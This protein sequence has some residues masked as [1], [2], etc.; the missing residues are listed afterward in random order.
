VVPKASA[1]VPGQANAEP[2]A[3]YADHINMVKFSRNNDRGYIKVS[4]TLQIMAMDAKGVIQSRW[5]TEARVD[6]GRQ[7]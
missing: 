7:R 3:I 4:E 1:V 5:E 6:E 2:I